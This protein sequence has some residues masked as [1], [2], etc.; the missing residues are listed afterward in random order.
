MKIVIASDHGGIT[1]RK[2]IAAL[3]E[4]MRIEY[5]DLGCGGG[6]F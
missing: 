1:I 2:E 6:A 3:L 5:I 4:E